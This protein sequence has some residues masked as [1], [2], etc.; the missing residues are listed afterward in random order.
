MQVLT[1]AK[2]RIGFSEE[3]MKILLENGEHIHDIP[4]ENVADAWK[5]WACEHDVSNEF[6]NSEPKEY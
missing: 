2:T 3:D 5:A 1:E 6:G 4:S